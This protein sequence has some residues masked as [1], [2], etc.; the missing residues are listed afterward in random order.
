MLFVSKKVAYV[1]LLDFLREKNIVLYDR[2]MIE[3]EPVDFKCPDL[4]GFDIIF[5][6]SQRAAHFYLENCSIPTSVQVATIGSTTSSFLR[7]GEINVDF[8]GKKSGDPKEV[9]SEFASFIGKRKVLFP[10]SDRS[11]RSMQ[12]ELNSDQVIDL[13]VYST[14]LNPVKLAEKCQTLVF[15][16]PSN[17]EAYLQKNEISNDQKVI[18]WGNT[19]KAFLEKEK[20]NVD[21]TLERSSFEELTAYLRKIY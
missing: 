4:K 13:V 9:A 10:Q 16:S 6:S 5:F 18:A 19:T 15:T 12:R 11:Q 14:I 17:V 20:I 8:E 21:H 2:S 3:F 1:P 7:K